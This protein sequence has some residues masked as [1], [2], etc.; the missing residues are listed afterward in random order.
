MTF[1]ELN[2]WLKE[3]EPIDIT[4]E[5]SNTFIPYS[6]SESTLYAL[7]GGMVETLK[8]CETSDTLPLIP[9]SGISHII[10]AM[11][12]IDT[13]D[14]MFLELLSCPGGCV[15]GSGCNSR[16][17]QFAFRKKSLD[18]YQSVKVPHM[19]ALN[20]IKIRKEDILT[21]YIIEN[22]LFLE[23]FN[24]KQ[25]K[26]VMR[27]L[28]KKSDDDN[29]DCGGCGYNS[30]HDF[31]IACLRGMGEK[32]MCVTNMRKQA[33]KKVDMILR[34]LPMGVVII[35][36]KLNIAECNSEFAKMFCEIDFEPDSKTIEKFINLPITEF[37]DITSYLNSII[38][39][40]KTLFQERIKHLDRYLRVSFFSIEKQHM[41]GVI[42]Q[43]IT[44]TTAKREIVIKKAEEV[45]NKNL[46][47]VQQIASLLGE[48]AAETE[49]ILRSLTDE[50]Q[51]SA[52]EAD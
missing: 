3:A 17:K 14:N 2:L 25:I 9:I 1:D 40:T 21:N 44:D 43:D 35:N 11:A 23:D 42:F 39:G 19:S 24:E 27:E 7:E 36:N 41:A 12:Q 33:Q 34:T 5:G 47:N 31:A 30:C 8:S 29:L 45:I 13:E 28:G 38:W 6:A 22:P 51:F 32:Q 10:D 15:N 4:E 26:T 52:S 49:I 16:E 50:F 20:I 46:Q 48:N 37:I 18:Y